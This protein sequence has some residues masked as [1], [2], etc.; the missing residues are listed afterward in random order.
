MNTPYYTKA[1]NEALNQEIRKTTSSGRQYSIPRTGNTAGNEPAPTVD[2]LYRVNTAGTFTNFGGV[3]IATLAN[4]QVDISVESNKTVFKVI[5]TDFTLSID[6]TL[7]S[8]STNA[9]QSGN[10]FDKIALKLDKLSV[11]TGAFNVAD[12]VNPSSQKAVFDKIVLLNDEVQVN[13]DAKVAE[14]EIGQTTIVETQENTNSQ[15]QA[16]LE[17]TSYASIRDYSFIDTNATHYATPPALVNESVH[18][19]NY[20]GNALRLQP[21][22]ATNTSHEFKLIFSK[23]NLILPVGTPFRVE[24]DIVVDSAGSVPISIKN[25]TGTTTIAFDTFTFE[26]NVIQTLVWDCVATNTTNYYAGFQFGLTSFFKNNTVF[27]GEHRIITFSQTTYPALFAKSIYFEQEKTD[28]REYVDEKT[29]K[30][31]FIVD[32][33][34]PLFLEDLSKFIIYDDPLEITDTSAIT[35]A[36]S[37]PSRMWNGSANVVN[38]V[39]NYSCNVRV[40]PSQP[41][42]VNQSTARRLG[43]ICEFEADT[44][45]IEFLGLNGST[46]FRVVV[47]DVIV[48]SQI[49]L[50]SSSGILHLKLDFSTK[51]KRNIKVSIFGQ[52]FGVK[53]DENGEIFSVDNSSKLNFITEGDSTVEGTSA[54]LANMQLLS[55]GGI[56]AQKLGYNFLNSAVGGSGYL[57][58]GNQGEPNMLNRI[59]SYV[60]DENPDVFLASMGY[61]DLAYTSTNWDTV[62]SNANTYWNT[63]KA[64]LPNCKSIVVGIYN[65][66]ANSLGANYL[67]LNEVLRIA[68]KRNGFPF[69]NPYELKTYDA[70]GNLVT[71]NGDVSLIT[72]TGRIGTEAI[73]INGNRSYY[74]IADNIHPSIEMHRYIGIWMTNEIYKLL[75]NEKGIIEDEI[76]YRG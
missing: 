4:K 51:S 13:L 31:Q 35:N 18:P 65:P 68:A 61:N 38:P 74:I 7:A 33:K 52:F 30:K 69:I 42:D 67:E 59:Q 62:K 27:I 50:P 64:Q 22:I 19:F 58:S 25:Q 1:E 10:T 21:N 54:S 57:A 5:A 8:G 46:R 15:W 48:T 14:Y 70:L 3:V 16:T 40:N 12:N 75:K 47:D 76:I 66:N 73:P 28:I 63:I 71:N 24:I 39:F 43:Y 2:G 36:T 53:V 56:I 29:Y 17:N 32:E 72:G 60:I 23:Y 26:E 45:E 6:S 34:T 9:A 55:W 41:L 20:V 44:K 11:N 49:S 37:Y